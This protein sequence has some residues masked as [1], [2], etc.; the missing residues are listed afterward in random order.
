MNDIAAAS[1]NQVTFHPVADIFPLMEGEHLE[2][3]AADIKERGLE[4]PILQHDGQIVDG[5]NRYRACMLAGIQPTFVPVPQQFAGNLLGFVLSHNLHR[6]HLNDSQRAVIAAKLADLPRGSNQHVPQGATSQQEAAEM[7]QVARRSV[8]RARVVQQNAVPEVI[9][10]IERGDLEVRIAAGI[11]QLR[12]A[13]GDVRIVAAAIDPELNQFGYIV[14]G[15]GD[16][17]DRYFGTG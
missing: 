10:R 5:R 9:R 8:Q 14:P 6:R 3:L 1:L 2:A 16:A 7:M 17:G 11:A 15:L 4:I 12:G 13:H